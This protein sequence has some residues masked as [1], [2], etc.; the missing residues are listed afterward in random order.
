[1]GF[2]PFMGAIVIAR[3]NGL[4]IREVTTMELIGAGQLFKERMKLFHSKLEKG[5]LTE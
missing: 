2:R 1:M 3:P 4:Q 5:E